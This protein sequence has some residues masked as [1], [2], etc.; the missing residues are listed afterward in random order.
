MQL[1]LT[2]VRRYEVLSTYNKFTH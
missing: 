1:K 2:E